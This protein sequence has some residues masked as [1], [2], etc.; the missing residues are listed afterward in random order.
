MRE[1]LKITKP[2]REAADA[3]T[4]DCLGLYYSGKLPAYPC[5]A[6]FQLNNEGSTGVCEADLDSTVTQLMMRYLTSR[7]GY[8]SD[9][10]ID[11]ASSQ[12]IY[13]HCVATNRV[14]GPNGISNP[15]I[16]R[17]HSEDRKGASVQ[18]VIPLEEIVT[19][20]KINVAEKAMIIHQGKAM[21]NIEE[22]KAC[23]TKLAVEANAEKIVENWNRNVDFGWHR[24][25]FC[26]DWR[27]KTMNLATLLG[28]KII[29]ED[30]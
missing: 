29:E 30:R 17:S 18:S 16:I 25:T 4:I 11:T 20:I 6:L 15:Y 23:R 26:G 10:V 14:Y 12:I 19:T 22:D 7:P 3:V 27:K 5:L 9:S 8:V 24:V 28:L 21:A 2:T 1:A 13:V